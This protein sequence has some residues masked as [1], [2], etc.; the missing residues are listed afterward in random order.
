MVSFVAGA[1]AQVII[2]EVRPADETSAFSSF[3]ELRNIGTADQKLDGWVIKYTPSSAIQDGPG[4]LDNLGTTGF[5][6]IPAGITLSPG[7]LAVFYFGSAGANTAAE[8]Y[9]PDKDP[10]PPFC[11]ISLYSKVPTDNGGLWYGTTLQDFVRFGLGKTPPREVVWDYD[12][13]TTDEWVAKQA[14][15]VI[16]DIFVKY[17]QWPDR[18]S[19]VDTTN[20]SNDASLSHGQTDTNSPKDW[21]LTAATPGKPNSTSPFLIPATGERAAPENNSLPTLPLT[22][23]RH[24]LYAAS[25]DHQLQ[26]DFPR[27]WYYYEM[28]SDVNNKQ[29]GTPAKITGSFAV[30]KERGERGL[31]ISPASYVVV[32]HNMAVASFGNKDWT[33]YRLTCTV[34]QTTG[35]FNRHQLCN[36]YLRLKDT[37]D[38]IEGYQFNLIGHTSISVRNALRHGAD[39]GKVAIHKAADIWGGG[40][41][42]F[43]QL[44]KNTA[45]TVNPAYEKLAVTIEVKG[46]A[47]KAEYDNGKGGVLSMSAVD[48]AYSSGKVGIG[49]VYGNYV[50]ND[51][52]VED[53]R[54]EPE[55]GIP[56]ARVVSEK[57]TTIVNVPIEFSA[58]GSIYGGDQ[59]MLTYLWDFGDGHRGRGQRPRHTFTKT[60]T[61]R[62][63]C[64]LRDGTNQNTDGLFIKVTEA[65]KSN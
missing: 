61:Y 44:T 54:A 31:W 5:Y 8:I 14:S 64:T 15:G 39:F 40:Q 63:T 47:I 9:A 21:I 18:D 60:G 48:D 32:N 58:A 51:I 7:S 43:T 1:D 24:I 19:Y 45:R 27:D 46:N 26:G 62:V 3:I 28:T 11:N 55:T 30:L 12:S 59:S 52:L 6:P 34:K 29:Y 33:D 10:V 53:L 22:D 50:F 23:T 42:T 20:L 16:M 25:F 56:V 35:D 36:F 57:E 38:C 17:K 13:R 4:Y 2:N 41:E 37:P 49:A 65:Q